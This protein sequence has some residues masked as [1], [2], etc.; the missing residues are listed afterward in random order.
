MTNDEALALAVQALE[1][2]LEKLSHQPSI[3]FSLSGNCRSTLGSLADLA[4]Q[5]QHADRV[6]PGTL[7][8]ER[9]ANLT[10]RRPRPRR[11][12][13]QLVQ[14][15]IALDDLGDPGQPPP[16]RDTAAR[17]HARLG[18]WPWHPTN[19]TS[20]PRRPK[21]ARSQRPR[22]WPSRRTTPPTRDAS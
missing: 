17:A 7:R 14:L 6:L 18:A 9:D 19:T 12:E 10:P 3:P 2:L 11:G 21:A 22:R 15:G 4:H 8:A 20:T 16:A 5:V 13:Q 1:Y